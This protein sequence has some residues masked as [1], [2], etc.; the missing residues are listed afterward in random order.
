MTNF[1]RNSD[2]IKPHNCVYS[3]LNASGEVARLPF[4]Q[5][6][7]EKLTVGNWHLFYPHD[8]HYG[9]SS[10]KPTGDLLFWILHGGEVGRGG[11]LKVFLVA[12]HTPVQTFQLVD[13]FFD[14]THTSNSI[15]STGQANFLYGWL[16]FIS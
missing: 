5:W 10:Q 14:A 12:G 1:H 15:L 13:Y 2:S 3:L 6:N 11:G 8:K 4:K 7:V 9:K 16:L